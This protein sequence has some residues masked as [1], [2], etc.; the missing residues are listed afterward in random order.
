MTMT[1][2]AE[3][4]TFN[5]AGDWIDGEI[6]SVIQTSDAQDVLTILSDYD[7][8]TYTVPMRGGVLK[9]AMATKRPEVGMTVCIRYEGEKPS[10]VS[11]YAPYDDYCV[12]WDESTRPSS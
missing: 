9:N 1:Q 5:D 8:Q 11:G 10:R 6:L 4:F 3:P 7:G 2:Q 12:A